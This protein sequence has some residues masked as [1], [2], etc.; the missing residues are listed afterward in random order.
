MCVMCVR[1]QFCPY[2]FSRDNVSTADL[3]L[4]PYNY[5]ID[6]SIRATLNL[7]FAGSILIFDEAHNL[8]GICGDSASFDW[9]S[10]TMSEA[11]SEVNRCIRLAMDPNRTGTD[12]GL[13]SH[14]RE[15]GAAMSAAGGGALAG[16]GG[17]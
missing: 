15:N 17:E 5:L 4:L 16:V 1:S 9:T 8:E 11:I 7:P 14:Y 10:Q 12:S 6:P 3:I 13:L 2:F